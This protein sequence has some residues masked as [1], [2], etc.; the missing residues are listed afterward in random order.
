MA[1]TEIGRVSVVYGADGSQMIAE[2][3]RVT[4]A[5]QQY[6]KEA[7]RAS[8]TAVSMGASNGR[9]GFQLNQI[10]YTIDDVSNSTGDWTQK[11][12]GAAN[13][14]GVLAGSLHPVAGLLTTIGLAAIPFVVKQFFDMADAAKDAT[15]ELEKYR[16]Q[17]AGISKVE[18]FRGNLL[19]ESADDAQKAARTAQRD[20][21]T[22]DRLAAKRE[23]RIRELEAQRARRGQ[24]RDEIASIRVRA[25]RKSEDSG[26]GRARLRR[27]ELQRELDALNALDLDAKLKLEREGV[28]ASEVERSNLEAMLGIAKERIKAAE[29]EEDAA[30]ALL[31]ATREGEAFAKRRELEV[32]R[33]SLAAERDSLLVQQAYADQQI[34]AIA[35]QLSGAVASVGAVGAFER[36]AG[37]FSAQ[38][39]ASRFASNAAAQEE[40]RERKEM[41][42]TLKENTRNTDRYL[43]DINRRLEALSR[44]IDVV[45]ADEVGL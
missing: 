38:Q 20:L 5:T 13:N 14:L 43:S 40:R 17:L 3:R 4:M 35:D 32:E 24:V 41:L 16:L 9:L 34:S 25:G 23:Q 29:K 45:S 36:G 18:S 12:R 11:L 28:T 7:M 6:S 1:K 2:T 8:Q 21:E 30:N 39:A 10:A 22:L 27:Q 31:S 44:E 19:G 15:S 37:A 33:T 26:A 42:E